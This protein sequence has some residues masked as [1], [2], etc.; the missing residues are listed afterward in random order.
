MNVRLPAEWEAQDGV[1]LAWPHADSD[2]GEQLVTV[3]PVF[4]NLAR[5]ISRFERVLI[6][7]LPPS[8]F[9]RAMHGFWINFVVLPFTRWHP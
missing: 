6:E 1:L 4:V 9:I 7:M 8:N 2:W 5:E 3:E